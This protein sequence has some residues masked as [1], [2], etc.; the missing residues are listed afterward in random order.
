MINAHDVP[1]WFD[2]LAWV[3]MP[4]VLCLPL[5]LPSIFSPAE[6]KRWPS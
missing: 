5:L 3:S 4:S 1:A 6:D 2:A